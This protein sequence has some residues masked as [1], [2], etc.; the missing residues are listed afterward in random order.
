MGFKSV[1]ELIE[2]VGFEEVQR[3]TKFT[4]ELVFSLPSITSVSLQSN[5]MSSPAAAI[6]MEIFCVTT[7]LSIEVQ[8]EFSMVK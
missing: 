4:P 3:Y 8:T 5:S 1:E 7:T 6:G 2:I